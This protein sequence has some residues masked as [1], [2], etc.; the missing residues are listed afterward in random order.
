MARQSTIRF[1]N[2]RHNDRLRRG[3]GG[4]GGGGA[5]QERNMSITML[6]EGQSQDDFEEYD[7][8]DKVDGDLRERIERL[9][10][11]FHEIKSRNRKG[12]V[13]DL[14]VID[15]GRISIPERLDLFVQAAMK[16]GV[17]KQ[18]ALEYA[19]KRLESKGDDIAGDG[20]R[21]RRSAKNEDQII[22]NLLDG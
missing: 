20:S 17:S 7:E 14:S 8:D 3:G 5:T 4:G 12:K 1:N 9:T 16:K 21:S 2:D 18:Q 19:V 11:R 6:P 13:V 15:D 22:S 10:D